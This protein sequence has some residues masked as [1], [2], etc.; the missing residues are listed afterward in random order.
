MAKVRGVN[1]VLKVWWGSAVTNGV[2]SFSQ[3]GE[4]LL[5]LQCHC[6][7]EIC[8]GGLFPLGS[9]LVGQMHLEIYPFLLDCP[10]C[11]NVGFSVFPIN[12]PDV[13]GFL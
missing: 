1:C 4:I 13:I 10:V 7:L 12:M 5:L 9:I 6:L 3:L 11:L 8:G 2:L